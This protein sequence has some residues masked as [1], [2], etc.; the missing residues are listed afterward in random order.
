MVG[1]DDPVIGD[2]RPD[3]QKG[4]PPWL[5]QGQSLEAEM[6][7]DFVQPTPELGHPLSELDDLVLDAPG[8]LMV[9]PLSRARRA[10]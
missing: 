8:S 9:R 3:P 2:Q 5:R 1:L 10:A 6:G 7:E 4:L